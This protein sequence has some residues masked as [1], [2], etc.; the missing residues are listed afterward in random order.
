M[1]NRYLIWAGVGVLVLAVG[2]LVWVTFRNNLQS[3]VSRAPATTSPSPLAVNTGQPVGLDTL[4]GNAGQVKGNYV[5]TAA[6]G[7]LYVRATVEKWNSQSLLLR[8]RD[9]K[10][11]VAVSNPVSVLCQPQYLTDEGG[12]R[13]L[14]SQ[15]FIDVTN[16]KGSPAQ[17]ALA[18]VKSAFPAGSDIALTAAKVGDAWQADILI[19]FGCS[20]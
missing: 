1:M 11:E 3:A 14:S 6:S 2:G 19:G 20:L 16:Y 17:V 9:K 15:V 12:N 13:I 5:L 10:S 18:K 8:I 7:K 4:V